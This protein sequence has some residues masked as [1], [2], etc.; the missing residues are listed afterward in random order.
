MATHS[1]LNCDFIYASEQGYT[2]VARILL[3][4]GAN[5]H[6]KNGAA[7]LGASEFGHVGTVKMLVTAGS[8]KAEI[9]AALRMAKVM[10]HTGTEKVLR[11]ALLDAPCDLST[12]PL[13]VWSWPD[14]AK[15]PTIP[16][17]AASKLVV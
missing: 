11:V 8:T 9:V 15:R 5:L 17:L 16:R 14:L 12:L 2:R 10:G 3:G 6:V 7:L 13:D 4:E 1:A